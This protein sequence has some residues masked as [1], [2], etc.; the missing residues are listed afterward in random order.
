LALALLL[1]TLR[2]VGQPLHQPKLPFNR[3]IA[4]VLHLVIWVIE[5]A[6][7]KPG[8]L[9]IIEYEETIEEAQSLPSIYDSVAGISG[10]LGIPQEFIVYGSPWARMKCRVPIER[11][12]VRPFRFVG[13]IGQW[14]KDVPVNNHDR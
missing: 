13:E 10:C 9:W 14:K 11:V 2:T 4:E 5:N 7:A 1:R 3:E 6:L 12:V 8:K